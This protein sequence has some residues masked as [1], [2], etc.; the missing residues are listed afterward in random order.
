MSA[1]RGRD[2]LG[3]GYVVVAATLATLSAWPVYES[4][5]MPVVAA[6]GTLAGLA[7]AWGA[8]RLRVGALAR[9]LLL[10]PATA[11]VFALLVVPVAIPSAV[12]PPAMWMA[13][14]RDGFAGVVV[15]WKQVLTL[16]LPLGEYQA[17]L[18]PLL[19]VMLV[20]TLLA[21]LLVAPDRRA[22]PLAVVVGLAMS[23]F[24]LVFGSSGLS[25]PVALGPVLVPAPREL[26]V[27]VGGVVAAV[28]WLLLRSRMI[29]G[30]ALRRASADTV[31][32][33]ALAGWSAWRRRALAAAI[34]L[35]AL[36][37]GAAVA[38][39]AAGSAHRE[40]VR[41]RIEPEVV[42]RQTPTPLTAYR[43][44]FTSDRVDQAWLRID[45]D[46]TGV[47]RLRLATLDAY[48]GETFHTSAGAESSAGVAS[49]FSRLPRAAAPSAGDVE[50]TVTVGDGYSGIWVP[51]PL[52]LRAAPDFSG[53]GAAVLDDGFH[54]SGDG[55]TSIDIAR[56]DRVD[57]GPE[58]TD[59]AARP[60]SPARGLEAGD[61]Y[62]LL[63]EPDRDVPLE[64]PG[65][66]PL[67]DL[68]E[69]P[70]LASWIELQAQPDSSAGFL[71]LVRRLRERG[72]LS[73]A[74]GDGPDAASWI[75]AL[76]S[77]YSFIPSYSGHSQARIEAL[78]AQLV[79]QQ[80]QA[81]PEASDAA[82]VAGV[83]DDEQFAVAVAL[84]ARAL[85]Y[86]SRVVLGF[87]LAGADDVAGVEACSEA[88][89]GGS[90]A[91]WTEVAPGGTSTGGVGAWTA[92]DATPQF[93]VAPSLIREGEQ[94]PEHP[95]T[96]DRPD[97]ATID[98]PSARSET[99]D[100][101]AEAARDTEPAPV[102]LP[103]WLR[104][105]AL[106]TAA[107]LLALLPAI[108][109][110]AAKR[111][112]SRRRRRDPSPEVRIVGAWEELLDVYAD[113][114]VRA[115]PSGSRLETARASGRAAAGVL[116]GIVERAVFA[117]D[118]PGIADADAAWAIVDAE[119]AA[120]AAA[121]RARRKL[122]ARLSFASLTRNTARPAARPAA[123][124]PVRVT[125]DRAIHEEPA[126]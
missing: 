106:A 23:G 103:A 6:A 105:T 73:H 121:S 93:E 52:G 24:G 67:L 101:E 34:V 1:T 27:A 122:G 60:A 12:G 112:R 55:A 86:D 17:V 97:T 57:G 111:S 76:G 124:T 49:R 36:V 35:V 16:A 13:G 3:L 53:A 14:I 71:E 126:R 115:G 47:E 7:L 92:I 70:A 77:G 33:A 72:Y 42:L 58:Q 4:V 83:G 48:D 66:S 91:A 107:V 50:F 51:A 54:R 117:A 39:V 56:V 120:L 9:A 74:A 41:D 119:R 30:V 43:S 15:G 5:R 79:E 31:Q 63:A 10:V 68:E 90:L 85:G 109:L 61:E 108:V 88:C 62:R 110:L 114:G 100:A 19:L 21:A 29:R 69:Y 46:T 102:V 38:P 78:F 32:R 99:N 118:P 95:T 87:R 84:V 98:P 75:G 125:P 45:G 116:A 123:S 89:A 18:V 64:Q 80:R 25:D 94:L 40:A 20:G 11:A 28:A 37:A 81:G 104:P 22:S 44:A 26:A 96:P 82:L 65:D 59:A 8:R 2:A 113:F